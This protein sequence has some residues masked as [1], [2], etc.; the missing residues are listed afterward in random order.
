MIILSLL[1]AAFYVSYPLPVSLSELF[2]FL[3]LIAK[4][5]VFTLLSIICSACIFPRLEEVSV[6]QVNIVESVAWQP[7]INMDSDT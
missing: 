2:F 6:G 1:S 3:L 7:D 5:F 4:F